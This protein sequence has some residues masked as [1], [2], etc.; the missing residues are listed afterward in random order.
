MFRKFDYSI[1]TY[2]D[3]CYFEILISNRFIIFEIYYMI[4]KGQMMPYS[5][6]VFYVIIKHNEFNK[7]F[8]RYLRPGYEIL[9]YVLYHIG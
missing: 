1:K 5:N 3:G 9:T 7:K 6:W 8:P 2:P 4:L